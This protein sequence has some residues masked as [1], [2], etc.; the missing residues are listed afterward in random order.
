[1]RLIPGAVSQVQ[2][3]G[4]NYTAS[5][6]SVTVTSVEPASGDSYGGQAVLIK[7][8][9]FTGSPT[10]TIG[11]NSPSSVVVTSSE[12]LTVTT[13]AGTAGKVD[14][15]VDGVTLSN[16]FIYRGGT[17]TLRNATVTVV[18]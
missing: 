10:V 3:G 6:A 7:G 18:M 11:G 14:V 5:A 13:P 9:G 1:M 15:V 12:I 2:Y 8:S 17:Y 4:V 16:G